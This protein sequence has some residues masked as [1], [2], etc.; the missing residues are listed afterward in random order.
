VIFD[1]IG[2]LGWNFPGFGKGEEELMCLIVENNVG[3]LSIELLIC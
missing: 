1:L 3:K 2:V